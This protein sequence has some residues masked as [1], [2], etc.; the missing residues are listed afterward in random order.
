MRDGRRSA[1][2]IAAIVAAM[3]LAGCRALNEVDGGATPAPSAPLGGMGGSVAVAAATH[4]PYVIAYRAAARRLRARLQQLDASN[5]PPT[6]PTVCFPATGCLPAADQTA[7]AAALDQAFFAGG[8]GNSTAWRAPNSEDSGTATVTGTFTDDDGAA[9]VTFAE[10]MILNGRAHP[11][12]GAACREDDSLWH[13][14][15]VDP[16]PP[17]AG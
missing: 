17:A 2:I 8:V 10:E 12:D 11:A 6:V 7:R 1:Y 13:V 5:T 4:D 16:R 14:V 15:D 3:S 9:C